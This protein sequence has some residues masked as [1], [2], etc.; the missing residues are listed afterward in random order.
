MLSSQEFEEP[1]NAVV[2]KDWMN[3]IWSIFVAN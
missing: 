3:Y 1:Q 2:S